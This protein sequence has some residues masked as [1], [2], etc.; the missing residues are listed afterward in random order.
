MTNRIRFRWLLPVLLAALVL[1]AAVPGVPAASAEEKPGV[2]RPTV[3]LILDGYGLSDQTEHN[4]IALADTPV[5]DRLMKEY[6][7]AEGNASG[8]ADIAPTLIEM[9]GM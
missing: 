5:M 6:P 2:K 7:F 8:L 3:L 9:M 4:A 1:N